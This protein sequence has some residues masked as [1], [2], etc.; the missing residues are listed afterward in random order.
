MKSHAVWVLLVLVLG[1]ALGSFCLVASGLVDAQRP[2]VTPTPFLTL[3]PD[4][5]V[6]ITV[7]ATASAGTPWPS[8]TPTLSE[9]SACV[10]RATFVEDVTIPDNARLLPGQSFVK[11][12]RLRNSGTCPWDQVYALVFVGGHRMEAPTEVPFTQSVSP[13]QMVDLSVRMTTPTGAGTYKGEWQLR[14]ADGVQ[15]GI[16]SRKG[17]SFWVRVVVEPLTTATPT[18]TA[19]P[20]PTPTPSIRAWRG[21]YFSNL[22]LSGPP[23]LTR[24]D[25]TINFTWGYGTPDALVPSDGF[26]ARWTRR[27]SFEVGVYRFHARVDDGVRV[28]VDDKLVIDVWSDGGSREVTGEL[29]LATGVHHV[30]VEYYERA[31]EAQIEVG[32]TRISETAYPD[33]KG[34]YW[35]NVSLQGDP[36][37]VR[38]DGGSTSGKVLDFRW[39]QGAP[40]TGLP[41][42]AF[43]ARWTRSVS[44]DAAT[45]RFYV[46]VDDGA[47]LWVDDTLVIDAWR[48]GPPREV[49]TDY[50]MVRG[51]HRI[52]VEYYERAGN[53]EI[54]VGWEKREVT[55]TDWKGMYWSNRELRGDPVL[56]RNDRE[57]EFWWGTGPVA[58]GLPN[59]DF[60]A[61]WSRDVDF[62]PG[63]YRFTAY[64]DDG[65]RIHVDDKLVLDEWHTS[66]GKQAYEADRQLAGVHRLV[67]AYYEGTGEARVNVSWQKIGDWPAPTPTATP[68]PPTPTETP[69][70]PTPTVTLTPLPPTPT[71]PPYT[72]T[73]PI[74]V[75]LVPPTATPGTPKPPPPPLTPVALR[76]VINEILPV[77]KRCNRVQR[78]VF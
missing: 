48:D 70:L 13:G 31:G 12:W 41:T 36:I 78:A 67:I 58:A 27:L 72:P 11:T 71:L 45:Y 32:W 69:V 3:T 30:R 63:I 64:A 18:P 23:V 61:R 5:T 77:P 60:S 7:T 43:S 59:D 17:P 33:W 4:G 50:A 16:D 21:E 8:P 39:G 22:T 65:I 14:N 73:P 6:P 51:A 68:I 76:V 25:A 53:A 54:R 9:V 29:W 38:A 20:T 74:I 49:A 26:S 57:V 34:E 10:D 42:D 19:S 15:F 2:T 1:M 40:A 35:A 56:V 24:D 44:F 52:K 46:I 28:Y 66:S 55:Y 75:T 62:A 47:R 37:L